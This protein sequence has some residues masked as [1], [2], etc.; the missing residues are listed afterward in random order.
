[1][2]PTKDRTELL[3]TALRSICSQEGVAIEVLVVDDG[4]TD[5]AAVASV[6]TGLADDRV[7]VLRRPA[8]QGVSAARNLGLEATTGDWVAFCDD[9]DLWAP[10]KLARQLGAL[11]RT[12]LAWAYAGSVDI[13]RAGAVVKG[14]PPPLPDDVVSALPKANVIPG[15][16]SG[17]LADRMVLTNLGGFDTGLGPCADWD[18]WL[19]LLAVGPPACAREPLVGYRLHAGNMSLDEERMVAD[20]RILQARYGTVDQ[21]VFHRYLFWWA[22]RSQ[23]RRAAFGH[24]V[25]AARTRPRSVSARVLA[26]DL[27]HL[28]G[29][30]SRA[31]L[32]RSRYGRHAL[33]LRASARPFPQP[34]PYLDAARAWIEAGTAL[35]PSASVVHARREAPASSTASS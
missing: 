3:G 11:E 17:V 15:G 21:T 23:R 1:V 28:L 31:L 25:A 13:G 7:R 29:R 33:R 20:F 9:D 16:C 5:P 10:D 18:L 30:S 8:P 6:V 34:D 22:L 26:R 4:S 24:W 14:S 12:G 2:V 32:E 27:T 35:P 19:R